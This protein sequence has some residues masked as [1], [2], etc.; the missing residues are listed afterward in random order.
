MIKRRNYKVIALTLTF[1]MLFASVASAAIP[2]DSVI[3]GDKAYSI[4]YVTNPANAAE[5]Q[6]ALDNLGTGMLAYNIDGQTSGWTSIMGGTPL[7]ADQI[8]ALP[9]ITYKNDAGEVSNY[10]AG[11]GDLI[12]SGLAVSN[13]VADNGNITITMTGEGTPVEG[14]FTFVSRIDGAGKADLAVSNFNWT[15]ATKT[16]AFTF[17]PFAATAAAQSIEI[18]WQYKD[19]KGWAAA[20][21]VPAA[22]ALTV[23]SVS[24]INKTTIEVTFNKAVDAVD[25]ANFD[26]KVG[27]EAKTV[28]SAVLGADKTK[29]TI[30]VQGL[31]YNDNVTIVVTGVTAGNATVATNSNTIKVP[32]V[33]DL[34]ELKLTSDKAKL[35]ANGADNTV[36]KAQMFEKA[37]PTTPVN[38]D[39]TLTMSTT[40]GAL[41]YTTVAMNDGEAAVVLTSTASA[42]TVTAYINAT[43]A[44]VASGEDGAFVGIPAETLEI[45]FD[46]AGSGDS[47]E[48]VTLVSAEA[49]TADRIIAKFSGKI[50]KNDIVSQFVPG[51][52]PAAKLAAAKA[53]NFGFK[54]DGNV[55]VGTLIKDVVSVNDT[56]LMLILNVD[57]FYSA[58]NATDRLD[59]KTGPITVINAADPGAYLRDNVTHNLSIPANIGTKVVANNAG[60]DFIFTDPQQPYIAG[61]TVE[62]QMTLR[63]QFYEAMAED[64]CE[65]T[66][67]LP[68]AP[69]AGTRLN[70]HFRVDGKPVMIVPAA[71]TVA[72]INFANLNNY[73]VATGL[74]VSKDDKTHIGYLDGVDTR[75]F[76][77]IKLDRLHK[78]APGTYTL[79]AN[80]VGDWAALTDPNNMVATQTFDFTVTASTT[81][82]TV[83]LIK[84][85]PEQWLLKFSENVTTVTG[86][87]LADAIKIYKADGYAASPKEPLTNG[88]DY[89][90]ISGDGSKTITNVAMNPTV[91]VNTPAKYFLIEFLNDW[92]VHYNTSVSGDNY[93]TS[94]YNPY[95]VAVDVVENAAGNAIVPVALTLTNSIDTVS[96]TIEEV[97][98]VYEIDG[99]T[100]NGCPAVIGAG[101]SVYVKMNEPVQIPFTDVN[102]NGTYDAGVDMLNT[103]P[104][105][106]SEQQTLGTGIPQPTFEFVKGD[107]TWQGKLVD[108]PALTT[109]VVDN[110][111]SFVIQPVNLAGAPTTLEPGTWTLIIRSISDD[112]GNTSATQTFN[113][114][115]SGT[116]TYTATKI[117]WAAFDDNINTG[118]DADKDYLYI[119][120]TKP[121]KSTGVTGVASSA[122]YQFNAAP[123]PPGNSVSKG[124]PGVTADWDGVTIAMPKGTWGTGVGPSFTCTLNVLNNLEA[125]DG[126]LLSGAHEVEL[127]DTGTGVAVANGDMLFEAQY[128]CSGYAYALT[129]ALPVII[130]G[131]VAFDANRD[132]KI[133]GAVLRVSRTLTD[134]EVLATGQTLVFGGKTTAAGYTTDNAVTASVYQMLCFNARLGELGETVPLAPGSAADKYVFITTASPITGTDSSALTLKA[135]DGAIL[136]GAA[137]VLDGAEPVVI[138]AKV[139]SKAGGTAGFGNDIGDIL[140]LT[141]SEKVNTN[142]LTATAPLFGDVNANFPV[143]KNGTNSSAAFT[144]ATFSANDLSKLTGAAGTQLVLNVASKDTGAGLIIA[145]TAPNHATMSTS[146]PLPV[147]TCPTD[148]LGNYLAPGQTAINIQ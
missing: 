96:P 119:K 5:I 106:P 25:P 1:L 97:K 89:Q 112:V 64:L 98:D 137:R 48:M 20:F 93:Y 70:D 26:V 33:T 81:K 47:V 17:A 118:T 92:T 62:E 14:D 109:T 123:L 16:V 11:D 103:M 147:A 35:T 73:I 101:Q 27:G 77:T 135:P 71:A 15:E 36:I 132:G 12:P 52:T 144:D 34:Y 95:V 131:S 110:D 2:T 4:G 46:P 31:N 72:D 40:L 143:T 141:F 58:A 124:I 125:A 146:A 69:T 114:T 129:G 78:L 136:I 117:A 76:V 83:E 140:T 68:G 13:V 75:N 87:T 104:L 18:G 60:K 54:V 107:L 116:T 28:Q 6:A 56:T 43:V 57:N 94:T 8:T 102:G 142:F 55:V 88:V 108:L 84:Q 41:S 59:T 128:V 86:K 121:M 63:V 133:D 82:P 79:Q 138:K 3:I 115:I 145:G 29:A 32:K 148:L 23:S 30:T 80:N 134:V 51:G 53:A 21:T 127:T 66:S 111:Y 42:K 100:I 61:V 24:A 44:A 90:I 9:P 130:T 50:N 105:T 39:A 85:S 139:T 99:K 7:T 22:E 49:N 19:S 45:T 67:A 65:Q 37:N 120:F 113:F 122:V 126:E 91:A 10:A 74:Y 38:V